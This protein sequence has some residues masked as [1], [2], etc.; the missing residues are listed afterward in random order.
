M[1]VLGR[2]GAGFRVWGLGHKVGL[3][4]VG[5]LKVLRGCHKI[6]LNTCHASGSETLLKVEAQ[7][8]KK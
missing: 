8:N 3:P 1:H 2:G 4:G 7:N 5:R 6:P